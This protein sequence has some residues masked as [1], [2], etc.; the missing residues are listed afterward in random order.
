M[1]ILYS[2]V[3]SPLPSYFSALCQELGIEAQ[4]FDSA[5]NLHRAIQK[6]PPDF[7]LGKF[8]H[9]WGN[10]YAGATISNL[11]VTLRTLQ[12]AAPGQRSSWSCSPARKPTSASCWICFPFMPC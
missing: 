12:A 10:D 6:H 7:F 4:R 2:P 5:R 1:S 11:D 3:A 9:G 8:I